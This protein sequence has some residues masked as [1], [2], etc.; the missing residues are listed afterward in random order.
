MLACIGH[1][2]EAGMRFYVDAGSRDG[3]DVARVEAHR[4]AGPGAVV[5]VV[6]SWG[7]DVVS[8]GQSGDVTVHS[9]GPKLHNE[10]PSEN[11]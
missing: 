3:G 11:A 10:T 1:Q 6:A 9:H 8:R 4:A 7:L 5:C 2:Q